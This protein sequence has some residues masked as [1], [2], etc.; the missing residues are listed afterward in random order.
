MGVGELVRMRGEER[1]EVLTCDT[2]ETRGS[3]TEELQLPKYN[4][5]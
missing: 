5:K 4:Y 1:K 2:P 3:S